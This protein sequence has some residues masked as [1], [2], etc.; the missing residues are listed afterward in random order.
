[1]YFSTRLASETLTHINHIW[2]GYYELCSV[3][4]GIV[5]Y[6]ASGG[7][8]TNQY[9]GYG[10]R[11]RKEH[12][13]NCASFIKEEIESLSQLYPDQNLDRIFRHVLVQLQE[14]HRLVSEFDLQD[15]VAVPGLSYKDALQARI[16]ELDISGLVTALSNHIQNTTPLSGK[17]AELVTSALVE[18][19]PQAAIQ[20]I[21]TIFEDH[22]RKRIGADSNLYGKGLIKA[23]FGQNGV[24]TYGE[25]PA[26]KEGI[27]SLF[28]GAYLTFRNP[29]MHRIVEDDSEIVLSIISMVDLLIKVIDE[30]QDSKAGNQ[31][32][33]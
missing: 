3:T 28:F 19:N 10:E 24:L 7:D 22:L 17:Q 30:A 16:A 26:E 15:V 12:I 20:Q 8:D 13:E 32:T 18:Q 5:L 11:E 14:I 2:N 27:R 31:G 6:L 23:A 29:R 21:F 4:N 1:M 33:T 9:D 25:T